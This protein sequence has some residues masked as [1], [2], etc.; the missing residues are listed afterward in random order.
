MQETPDVVD[1]KATQ[2]CDTKNSI[3][4]FKSVVIFAF[5]RSMFL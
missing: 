2:K 3:Y 1:I 5:E 4:L